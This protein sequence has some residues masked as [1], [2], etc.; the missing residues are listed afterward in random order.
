MKFLAE[1]VTIVEVQAPNFQVAADK[2]KDVLN[3]DNPSSINDKVITSTV[4]KVWT[5]E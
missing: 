3:P 1:V 5:N 2:A 4:K